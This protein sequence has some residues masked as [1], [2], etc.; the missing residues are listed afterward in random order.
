ME[1]EPDSP[2]KAGEKKQGY[3]VLRGKL[4]PFLL[5]PDNRVDAVLAGDIHHFEVLQVGP[6]P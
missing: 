1:E 4:A 5:N 2:C 6:P 3:D